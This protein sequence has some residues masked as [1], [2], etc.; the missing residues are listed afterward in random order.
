MKKKKKL[1]FKKLSEKYIDTEI[2]TGCPYFGTCGGCM[3]RNISYDNQ[4]LL[5]KEHLNNLFADIYPIDSVLPSESL[6]YRNRMDMVTAFGKFGLREA[7]SYKF[8]VD[9]ESCAIMQQKMN[10]TYKDLFAEVKKI[11]DYDYLKHEGYLRYLI[12]RQAKFTGQVMVN[13]V[14]SKNENRLKDIITF[15]QDK[16]DSISILLSDGLADLSFGPVIEDVKNGYI[17]EKFDDIRYRITPNSFFQSNSDVAV[18]MYREIKKEIE[19]TVLDLY[20]GVGSISLFVADAAE[21]VTGVESVKE[22]VDN[23]LINSSI[24][25]INNAEFICADATEYFG[26]HGNNFNTL[27]LDPPRSGMHPKMLK[28]IMRILPDKIIY[29]SCNPSVFREELKILEGYKI[30]SF[31]AF[32]MFP[33][34]PH[35]ETLA[36][37]KRI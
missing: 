1:Y 27:I 13:F 18:K 12:F 24:N 20:S 22:A 4:L 37:L 2:D 19:G 33:Y 17:E 23:A 34:T 9:I 14:V 5:K 26:E 3:F 11:E 36:V 16:V 28:H 32:D 6:E 10:S 29:M 35:V 30:E 25:N 7:G 15:L 31:K 8:V 21:K